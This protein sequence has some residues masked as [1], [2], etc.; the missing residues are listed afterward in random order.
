MRS[1]T[2]ACSGW[3]SRRTRGTSEHAGPCSQ[4]GA[5][6]EGIFRKHMM[7]PTGPRDSAWYAITEDDWPEVKARLLWRLAGSRMRCAARSRPFARSRAEERRAGHAG[8]RP[9]AAPRRG[10]PRRLGADRDGLRLPR[11]GRAK[12]PSRT[13]KARGP[14]R[15]QRCPLE[16]ARRYLG[17][18]YEWGGLTE[19]GIDCS[20]L[21]HIAYRATGRLVPRDSWQQ[22]A[23]GVAVAAGEEQP[24]DLVTY[25]ERRAGRPRRVLARRGTTSFTRPR[26]TGWGSSRRPE[27]AE[28]RERRRASSRCVLGQSLPPAVTKR[29]IQLKQAPRAA[30]T[31]HVDAAQREEILTRY[32]EH[33]RRFQTV[34]ARRDAGR[35]AD[36]FPARAPTSEAGACADC[37]RDRGPSARLG[38][39]R[40]SRDRRPPLPL[41]GDGQEP[42][43]PSSREASGKV[44]SPRR[45]RWLPARA[46]DLDLALSRY[47]A[48][49]GQSPKG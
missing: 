29:G 41:G 30:D 27:P 17:A 14:R 28:L 39:A 11:L 5:Q 22:E 12:P 34:A 35:R 10:A 36:R 31:G 21:V 18:P 24:G 49:D 45:S 16:A 26:A 15:R 25:G 43:P 9:R 1:S 23:A 7:L 2:A 20:G 3:S 33:S 37:P 19:A 44:E 38:R 8:A 6:F 13:A 46:P 48:F 47:F 42:R 40:Q 4:L 32:R